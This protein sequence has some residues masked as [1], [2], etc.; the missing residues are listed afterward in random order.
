MAPPGVEVTSHHMC[1]PPFLTP[2]TDPHSLRFASFIPPLYVAFA[3]LLTA[4]VSL[5]SH[6]L[7]APIQVSVLTHV[8]VT[9]ATHRLN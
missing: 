8:S 4:R 9:T 1:C 2:C 5:S 6:I 7:L 3:R